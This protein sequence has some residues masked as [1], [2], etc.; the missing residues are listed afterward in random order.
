MGRGIAPD[1]VKAFDEV[2]AKDGGFG[3]VEGSKLMNI[4]LS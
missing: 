4:L 2:L 1:G 3:L